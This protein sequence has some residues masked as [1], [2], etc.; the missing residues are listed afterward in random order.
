MGAYEEADHPWLVDE[1]RA[2]AAAH[3]S[4]MPMLGIC[5]GAQLFADALGGSAYLADSIPEIAHFTPT[6]TDAGAADPV[7]RHFD[8]PVV[9][10]HQDTWD[11]PPTATLLA[12]SDRFNHAF[13]LGLAVAIQAHPEAD[14]DIVESWI[15]M[16]EELP[17]LE[18]S[19]VDGQELV[20]ET[21]AGEARQR[22]MAARLFGAWVDEIL[23]HATAR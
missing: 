9:A 7:L 15:S 5:L 14:G 2:I 10:F 18:A 20:A 13:R 16:P 6:L 12:N 19:G 22:E 17:L 23:V 8:I 1:K 3:A 21:R 11:L 4:G